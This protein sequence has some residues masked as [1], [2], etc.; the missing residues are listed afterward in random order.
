MHAGV[1]QVEPSKFYCVTDSS[2]FVLRVVNALLDEMTRLL[3]A[4]QFEIVP[5]V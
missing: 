5:V 1:H 2:G 3:I 4:G